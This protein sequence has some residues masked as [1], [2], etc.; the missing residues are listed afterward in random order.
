MAM[1]WTFKRFTVKDLWGEQVL[2]SSKGEEKLPDVIQAAKAMGYNENTTMFEI[3][4]ANKKAQSYKVDKKILFKL[5]MIILML[6]EIQ[7]KLLKWWK[8][9]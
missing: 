7:E 4:F 9:V 2:A 1:G 6:L 5:G 8:R 3:L